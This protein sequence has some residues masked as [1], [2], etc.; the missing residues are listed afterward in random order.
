MKSQT[1][2][3]LVTAASLVI[4]GYIFSEI[5]HVNPGIMASVAPL[6]VYIVYLIAKMKG[7]LR[8][9]NPLYWSG[10]IILITSVN[11]LVQMI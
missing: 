3:A 7:E 6:L 11:I 4:Q 9:D 2:I 1:V 5:L 8:H 10:A